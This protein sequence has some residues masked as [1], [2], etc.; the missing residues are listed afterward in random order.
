MEAFLD[1]LYT[2]P[3]RYIEYLFAFFGAMGMVLFFA[4]FGSGARHLFTFGESA[5][6][7]HHVRARIIWGILL[8]MVTLGLWEILRVILGLAPLS[9][10]ILSL[11]LLT[12][13]WIPWLRGAFKGG[14]GGH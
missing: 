7:M 9:Y 12:P 13:L 11:L 5:D 8:C 4:G 6:H 3:L 2:D 1:V 10:L 14:G